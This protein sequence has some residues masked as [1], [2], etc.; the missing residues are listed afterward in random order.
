MDWVEESEWGYGYGPMHPDLADELED[1][2]EEVDDLDE[3]AGTGYLLWEGL[4]GLE[5]SPWG[6]LQVLEF[7]DTFTIIDDAPLSGVAE[8]SEPFDGYYYVNNVFQLSFGE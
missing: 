5:L 7:D 2:F 3:T 6:Y 1:L 4:E 8:S